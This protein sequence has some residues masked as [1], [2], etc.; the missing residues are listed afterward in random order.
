MRRV[1]FRP[2]GCGPLTAA[3]ESDADLLK[4]VIAETFNACSSERQGRLIGSD[5]PGF[6]EKK[7][8]EGYF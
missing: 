1:R 2:L 7:K 8:R 3:I 6:M 4:A 5:V